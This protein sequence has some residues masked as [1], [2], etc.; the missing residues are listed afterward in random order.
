MQRLRIDQDIR[1]MSEFRTGIASFLKQVHDTKRP[2]I[3][4]QHGKGAAVLLDV[5]EYEAMQGKLE[6]LKDIQISIG[7]LENGEGIA[8]NEAKDLILK[9]VTK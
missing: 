7:Q 5:G 6:L 9:R 2:L 3:I 8:H 4:T 1:S